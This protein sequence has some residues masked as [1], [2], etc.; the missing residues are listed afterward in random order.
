MTFE[1]FP[2]CFLCKEDITKNASTQNC[3]WKNSKIL[4]IEKSFN[5]FSETLLDD[6]ISGKLVQYNV[7]Y[8]PGPGLLVQFFFCFR[9]RKIS[10]LFLKGGVASMTFFNIST[11]NGVS[12]FYFCMYTHLMLQEQDMMSNLQYLRSETRDIG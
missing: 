8:E 11:N 7:Y 6:S 1:K 3:F 9:T 12:R 5:I 2:H 10:R 4:Y